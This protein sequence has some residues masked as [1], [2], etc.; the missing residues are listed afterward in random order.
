M[1]KYSKLILVGGAVAALA[2]PSVAMGAPGATGVS[3]NGNTKDVIGYCVS[4]GNYNQHLAG[5]TT[6]AARSAL[7]AAEGPGAVA[8]MIKDARA[9]AI[10]IDQVPYAPPGQAS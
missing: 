8:Q 5:T 2:V 7:N 3:T 1:R 10:C 9:A 4:A 6:G